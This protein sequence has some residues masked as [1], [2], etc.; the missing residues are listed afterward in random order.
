MGLEISSEEMSELDGEETFR[1]E[2]EKDLS[3]S[4]GDAHK[5]GNVNECIENIKQLYKEN[6]EQIEME[7][8]N[9]RRVKN[10]LP[11]PQW[12]TAMWSIF[13]GGFLFGALL[14]QR[15]MEGILRKRYI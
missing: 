15:M 9:W 4:R 2:L 5:K 7:E 12:M 6:H 14:H 8:T 13:I 1:R 10:K 11:E 3:I